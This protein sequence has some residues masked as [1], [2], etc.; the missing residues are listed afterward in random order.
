MSWMDYGLWAL[1]ALLLFV[2]MLH[3]G[4]IGRNG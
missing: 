4:H 1:F 2:A 3:G